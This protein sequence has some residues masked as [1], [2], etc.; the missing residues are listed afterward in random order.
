[1]YLI[2]GRCRIDSGADGK[3]STE[4]KAGD[5]GLFGKGV[6]HRVQILDDGQCDYVFVRLGEGE[7]VV[8]VDGPG[9]RVCA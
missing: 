1:M 8:A 2:S 9:P 5:F 4:M 7:S 3:I 6:I